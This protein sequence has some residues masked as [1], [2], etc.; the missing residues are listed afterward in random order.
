[1]VQAP[2]NQQS[3][4]DYGKTVTAVLGMLDADALD[5]VL[6]HLHHDEIV[7]VYGILGK[8]I[9]LASEDLDRA[10]DFF[11]EQYDDLPV[12]DREDYKSVEQ[13][14]S[15]ILLCNGAANRT[16]SMSVDTSKK[17]CV[18]DSFDN[19][20]LKS[21]FQEEHTHIKA[22][23][24]LMASSDT[25]SRILAQL[26]AETAASVLIAASSI[27]FDCAKLHSFINSFL[28]YYREHFS[29]YSRHDEGLQ[30]LAN[31]LLATPAKY[32]KQAAGK[33][34]EL[35]QLSYHRV[36]HKGLTFDFLINL[37]EQEI[38]HLMKGLDSEIIYTACYGLDYEI[39]RKFYSSL[40]KRMI[41]EIDNQEGELLV[42][43]EQEQRARDDLMNYVRRNI[44]P[45]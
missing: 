27:K 13:G 21:L 11:Y 26:D 10:L 2:D 30:N 4:L 6:K 41:E 35:D 9:A 25:R 45:I 19:E 8:R 14:I 23:I 44:V 5:N 7:K 17:F 1:M 24:I 43:A 22:S 39:R 31:L 38:C 12:Y 42:T 40:P 18:A 32:R 36:L 3:V 29:T 16:C 28:V 20:M 34:S 33:F 37:S 15:R